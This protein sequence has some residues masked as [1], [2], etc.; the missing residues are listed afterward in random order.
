MVIFHS[1]VKNYQRVAENFEHGLFSVYLP[2]IAVFHRDNL[3]TI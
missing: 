3:M 1:Y 2:V